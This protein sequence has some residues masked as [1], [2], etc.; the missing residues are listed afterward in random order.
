[1]QPINVEALSYIA[2]RSGETMGSDATPKEVQMLGQIR[3]MI[4]RVKHNEVITISSKRP[5][6]RVGQVSEKIMKG[7]AIANTI[8]YYTLP[9]Q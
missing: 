7:K 6:S 8:E 9:N 2:P 1:M 3:L 5:L 4:E